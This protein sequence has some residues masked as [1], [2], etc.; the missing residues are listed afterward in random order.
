MLSCLVQIKM[1]NEELAKHFE[2]LLL[3][4]LSESSDR[5]DTLKKLIKIERFFL[6][7]LAMSC[8]FV[9]FSATAAFLT[10][11]LV[12]IG[13]FA[14]HFYRD[15]NQQDFMI[16]YHKLIRAYENLSSDH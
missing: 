5:L 3:I 13:L 2:L 1:E 7:L 9:K 10:F 14:L 4:A 11:V 8:T 15:S 6:L 16:F 12:I